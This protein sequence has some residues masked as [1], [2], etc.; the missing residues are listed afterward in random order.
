MNLV[1]KISPKSGSGRVGLQGIQSLHKCGRP[2]WM[3]GKG[4]WLR[5]QTRR[6]ALYRRG[7]YGG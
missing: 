7:K 1:L 3:V 4:G 5:M 2:L 6:Q